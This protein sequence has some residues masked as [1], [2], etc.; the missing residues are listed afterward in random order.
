M[1]L[2]TN[3]TGHLRVCCNSVPGENRILKE[4][5]QSFKVYRDDLEEAWNS[6]TYR[7]LRQELLLG[8][9]PKMC[10]RC[11]REERA[12]LKS[13]RMAWNEKFADT[14]VVTNR[15][16]CAP[17][18]VRYLDLRLGNLC[19]LRCRMCNPY[20]SK[21]WV[22]EWNSIV[23]VPL[24]AEELVQL[25]Q[26]DWPENPKMWKNLSSL[27]DSVE[28][29]YLTG[30]EPLLIDEQLKL[31]QI[32][33][34]QGFANK[35][36]LKYNTNLTRLPEGIVDLWRQFRSVKINASLDAVGGLNSYIRFPS[37]WPVIERTL[38]QFVELRKQG[39]LR[40]EVHTTV[41]VYNV[42][43]LPELFEYLLS[44]S[45]FPYLNI[46]NHPEAFNIRVLPPALKEQV[47]LALRPYLDKPKVAGLI[48]YL[49]EDW[50]LHREAFCRITQQLDSSRGQQLLAVCPELSMMFAKDWEGERNGRAGES[51]AEIIRT[52]I[53]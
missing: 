19:N 11:F 13:A 38:Q 43:R 45:M 27:L 8:K 39:V 3:A 20:A 29:I 18:Q 34:E 21:Q 28:E 50:G 35:I 32:C 4:D 41:Q 5:G 51:A 46:L 26:V 53:C 25:S 14:K 17:F 23:D 10:V 48:S 6:P 7:A 47:R 2:A 33:C 52:T 42:L 40:L 30:G 37:Q 22:R 15:E 31:L 12:G 16:G 1:H 9:E 49:D 36:S 44:M 24:A